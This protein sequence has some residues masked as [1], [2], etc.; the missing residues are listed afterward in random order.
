MKFSKLL[1]AIFG[2]AVV[3]TSCE[4]PFDEPQQGEGKK[5]S[6][7]G[8]MGNFT[9]A[10]DTAFEEGDQVGLHIVIPQ[11]TY[12]NNA[13]FTYTGGNLVGEESYYWYFDE[14]LE[15]NLYAYYP[16]NESASYK[17]SG[18]TFTVNSDQSKVGGYT[19]SDLMVAHTTSTP[20]EEAVE[21][22]FKHVLSKVVIKIDNQLEEQIENVWFSEVYGT[23]TV[24]FKSGASVVSGTKGTIKTAKVTKDGEQAWALILAPQENVTPKLIIT[25][26][27]KKQ[28]TYELSGAVSFS[29][30]KVSTATIT[31]SDDSIYTEFT[32]TITDWV[33]DNELQFGQ[34]GGGS[35]NPG[36]GNDNPGGDNTDSAA[37]Y[38]HPNMWDIDGA[39]FSAHAWNADGTSSEDVTLTDNDGDGVYE[40]NLAA[41][42][43]NILFCRMNPEFTSFSWD[44][45]HVWNQTADLTVGV[46]PNNHFHMTSWE[47]GAWYSAD[48]VFDNTGVA[49][50]LGVVGSFAAS[51]WEIDVVL[52][53]TET[54]GLL[55]AKNIEFRAYDAFKVRTVGSWADG[56]VNMGAGDVNYF[57]PNKYFTAVDR[58]GDIFVEQAGT[59]DIYYN[60]NNHVIYVMTAG[61][62]YTAATEQTTSGS[63]PDASTMKWGLA[64]THNGWAA[65]DV[66]L[67]WDGTIGL[68]VAKNV[69]LTGEFKVRA[70]ESWATNF[71][72]GSSVTV[73]AASATALYN[74]GGNCSVAAGTYDVYF[75]Y[76]TNNIK[77]NAKLWVKSV[78]SAAPSL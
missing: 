30:G 17:A 26:E 58:G 37:I 2:F 63:A 43:V 19:A 74:N 53:S 71:G 27:S 62:S 13:H 31:L 59:Y 49:S 21:L 67:T 73:N 9:R 32:P 41:G 25:T 47:A 28:Y 15:S 34:N 1:A 56:D 16:Y 24:N 42:M 8:T 40:A 72:S 65:P 51:N 12:L 14:T 50:G 3:A 78:G 77:A 22:P 6:L 52:T 35:E 64:G 75:W 20:T 57:T 4:A 54:S 70:D 66:A 33:D 38:F 29:A 36:G 11:G 7:V 76:D 18:Y 23:T 55:V 45:G 69:S 60:Q 48:Y 39:W 46:Y 61:T 68:Y 44:E 10:T 5:I